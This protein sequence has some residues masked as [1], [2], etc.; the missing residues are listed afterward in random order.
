LK[1]LVHVEQYD[2]IGIL[3]SQLE[4]LALLVK[5]MGV[6]DAAFIDGT[7]DGVK[8]SYG[9]TR[10]GSLDDFMAAESGPFIAFS[11]TEGED[12]S[13]DLL[14]LDYAWLVF[15][16]S[17]GRLNGNFDAWVKIPGGELNS[18]DA[19]PIALWELSKWRAQ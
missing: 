3:P 13:R 15:G 16:P 4:S 8:R 5:S 14:P 12:I 1:L 11:P 17:M 6:T 10:Y 7:V 19:V 2:V 18:R 9:F